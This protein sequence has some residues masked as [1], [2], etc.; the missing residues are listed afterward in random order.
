[1]QSIPRQFRLARPDMARDGMAWYPVEFDS[2]PTPPHCIHLAI[3]FLKK[4]CEFAQSS[5]VFS[6]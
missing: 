5:E 4:N 1:M 2:L 6:L 3:S